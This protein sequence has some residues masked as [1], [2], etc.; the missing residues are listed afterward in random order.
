MRA[1]LLDAV[2]TVIRLREPPA[3][4]YARIAAAHGIQVE[5]SEIE[6]KLRPL[7]AR[8]A[9]PPL[10][11][12][13]L[14]AIPD[15]EREQW[16][17]LIR[18]VLGDAAG[19]GDCFDELF[20]YYG[21]ASTWELVPGALRALDR[22]RARAVR[23]AVVS[24]MDA[25]L[26][27]LLKEL[28]LA[29]RLDSVVIPANSGLAKP[30]PRIFYAA[31]DRLEVPPAKSLYVGDRER[32]CVDAARA[33]GLPALRYDPTAHRGTANVLTSWEEL[34]DRLEGH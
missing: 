30:D 1:L 16:R 8:L 2:G 27:I 22:V 6:R 5:L 26:E 19:D 32:D 13:S 20:A 29:T 3:R 15:L 18:Q 23:V 21:V 12:V 25:R 11:G 31:L 14:D 4:V 24:N 10:L 34:A 33:A 9:P 17:R 28:G 7:L